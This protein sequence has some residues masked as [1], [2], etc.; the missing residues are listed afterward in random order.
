M[1]YIFSKEFI[2]DYGLNNVLE[3]VIQDGIKKYKFRINIAKKKKLDLEFV[4]D[5]RPKIRKQ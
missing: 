5:I 4:F 2:D 1:R 3:R